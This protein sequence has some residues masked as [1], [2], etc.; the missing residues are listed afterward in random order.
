MSPSQGAFAGVSNV[1]V[2]AGVPPATLTAVGSPRACVAGAVPGATAAGPGIARGVGGSAGSCPS[3]T[4]AELEAIAALSSPASS[5]GFGA[6]VAMTA[7]AELTAGQEGAA[8]EGAQQHSPAAAARTTI[9]MTGHANS[10]A[11]LGN[12]GT[13]A[14]TAPIPTPPTLTT[15]VA[16]LPK[17]KAPLAPTAVFSAAA[18]GSLLVGQQQALHQCRSAAETTS[19]ILAATGLAKPLATSEFATAAATADLGATGATTTAGSTHSSTSGSGSTVSAVSTGTGSGSTADH[20][21]RTTRTTTTVGTAA[22]VTTWASSFETASSIAAIAA[23]AST[24]F[25]LAKVKSER[26]QVAPAATAAAALLPN[27]FE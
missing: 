8:K 25:K 17:A 6:I 10:P 1:L 5:G 12:T 18:A 26:P 11:A 16:Y 2:R 14:P 7:Y 15:A 24:G 9:V 20:A 19:D 21:A 13:P 27:F 22:G 23:A 4:P 3:R